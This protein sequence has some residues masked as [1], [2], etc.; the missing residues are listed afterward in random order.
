MS[1]NS[2]DNLSMLK[3]NLNKNIDGYKDKLSKLIDIPITNAK[4]GGIVVSKKINISIIIC[5]V[6]I[7]SFPV[8][9]ALYNIKPAFICNLTTNPDTHFNENKISVFKLVTHALGISIIVTMI[10]SLYFTHK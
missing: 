10:L 8:G 2:V 5:F 1:N 6:L 3:E 9:F 4:K 7:G